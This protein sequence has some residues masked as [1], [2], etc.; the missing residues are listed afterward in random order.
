MLDALHHFSRAAEISYLYATKSGSIK[1]LAPETLNR[2]VRAIRQMIKVVCRIVA[3]KDA[4]ELEQLIINE[5]SIWE[6]TSGTALNKILTAV[7]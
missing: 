7:A 1:D 5:H 3:E 6:V 2:R 4:A